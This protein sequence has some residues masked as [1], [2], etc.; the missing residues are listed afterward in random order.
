LSDATPLVKLFLPVKMMLFYDNNLLNLSF[1]TKHLT[2]LYM[3][4]ND[5]PSP[6]WRILEA[7]TGG[8]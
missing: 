7:G 1:M 6:R 5:A 3:K 2:A 8:E 4:V